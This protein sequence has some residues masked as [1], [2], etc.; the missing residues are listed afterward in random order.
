MPKVSEFF[1]ISIYFYYRE[2]EPPHFHAIYAE[3]EALIAIETL[4]TLRG[5]LPP[6]AGSMVVEWAIMHRDELRRA[7]RLAR[8]MQPLP[9]IDPLA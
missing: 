6:R 1:G 4:E 2:H 5:R 7:W 3:N 9:R 8:A